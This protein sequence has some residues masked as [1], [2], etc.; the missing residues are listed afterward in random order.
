MS[1][2]H[3]TIP[4]RDLIPNESALYTGIHSSMPRFICRLIPLEMFYREPV[5]RS[6]ECW[7]HF[8][9]ADL[10]WPGFLFLKVFHECHPLDS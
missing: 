10:Y 5:Y 6:G 3:Q 1:S 4:D 8:L 7:T 9:K 2:S